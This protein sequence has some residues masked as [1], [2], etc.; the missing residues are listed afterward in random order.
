GY[1]AQVYARGLRAPDGLAVDAQGRLLVV[2]EGSGQITRFDGPGQAH[3][4]VRGLRSPE[5]LCL[6]PDGDLF[7]VEDIPGGRLLRIDQQGKLEVLA[8]DL[9]APEGVVFLEGRLFL[10][11]STAQQESNKFALRTRVLELTRGDQGWGPPVRRTDQG[12]PFSFAE[13]LCLGDTHLIICNEL[14]SVLIPV[15][16]LSFDLESGQLQPFARGLIA[17]EGLC[18]T[19][20]SAE[21]EDPG[22]PLYVA[23]EDVDGAG[24]GRISRVTAEGKRSTFAAGFGT[25]EDVL[26]LADGRVFVSE[27]STGSIVLLT[28]PPEAADLTR[29]PAEKDD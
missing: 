8:T 28:P 9:C 3:V 27:D 6:G 23:E 15:G 10:T 13:L 16:L 5:G 21:N 19:P 12:I 29:K 7:V 18:W 14:A 24:H 2:E 11:E 1:S 17:P 22:F 26:V 4:L 25:L 20:R